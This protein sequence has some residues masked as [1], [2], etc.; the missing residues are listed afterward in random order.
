[1]LTE[2]KMCKYANIAMIFKSFWNIYVFVN[3][4]IINYLKT[5]TKTKNTF[6]E[7]SI[8]E[9]IDKTLDFSFWSTLRPFTVASLRLG[10]RTTWV[11]LHT[12]FS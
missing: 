7:S 1:M 12:Y 6:W 10:L 8:L 4:I 5:K 11:H 2:K 9:E 3:F